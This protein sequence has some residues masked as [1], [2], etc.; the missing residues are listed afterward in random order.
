MS[1]EQTP[2]AG[3]IAII[4]ADFDKEPI[5]TGFTLHQTGVAYML[6]GPDFQWPYLEQEHQKFIAYEVIDQFLQSA[7]DA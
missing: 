2:K 5:P 6:V 3:D 7:I 4:H 1:D